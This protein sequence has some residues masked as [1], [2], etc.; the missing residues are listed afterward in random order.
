MAVY[1][2]T[3]KR[4]VGETT[5]SWAR[6]LVL[7]RYIFRDVFKSKFFLIVFLLGFL[8]PLAF[9][10]SIYLRNNATFLEAFP[11]FDIDDFLAIDASFFRLLLQV[12]FPFAFVTTLFVG[13]G[14]ISRDLANNS[15]P[16]YLSRPFSRS[17][18]VLGKFSVLAVLLSAVTWMP[19]WALFALEGNYAGLGW[20]TA[21]LQ[22]PI[23]IF[24][25]SWVWIVTVSLMALALSAWVRWRPV[26]AFMMLFVI[27]VGAF[28]GS[29]LI[30]GLF[31]VDWGHFMNL[32]IVIRTVLDSLFGLPIR[33]GLPQGLAWL[34]LAAFSGFFLLLLHRKIRAYEVVK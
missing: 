17:E 11:S 32:T 9:A 15:L 18:Y 19:G 12:Q 7:P 31:R 2:R 23:A 13:P 4:Y 24:I 34:S 28:I 8:W 16:L 29:V 33:S 25:G 30:N 26:A 5:P 22:L 1:E 6:I 20:M 14:L 27:L 21:N 3:Y 10:V